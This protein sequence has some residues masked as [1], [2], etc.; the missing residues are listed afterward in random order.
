MLRKGYIQVYTG[1]GKGKTTAAIGLAIRAL[2]AGLRVLLLQFMKSKVYSEHNLLPHISPNLTWETLGKPFFIAHEG[3]MTAEELAKWGD[4][5]VVFPPGKPP[6]E[7][8]AVVQSG[9]ERAKTAVSGG[10]YDLV[11]LDEINVAMLFELVTWQQMQEILTLRRPEVEL[12]LT[13][14]GAPQEL[15]DQADLVTEMKE[16]KHYYQQ[17][18]EARTGI[19]N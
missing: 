12:V 4:D 11:I 2:G 1:A 16:I 14:R 8:L 17:G 10:Q 19:E 15:I 6:R 18:V 3:A 13:G 7:Y 5:V 9:I